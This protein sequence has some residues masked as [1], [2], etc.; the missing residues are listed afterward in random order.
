ML[1]PAGEFTMG[2]D[3]GEE[4]E[5][6]PHRVMITEPFYLQTTEVTQA[7]W[8]AVMDRN[9][10][11]L[12]GDNFPV[13][14][15]SWH[16]AQEFVSRLSMKEG[17]TYRL[18][19]EAEWEYACRAGLASEFCFGDS[20][21]ELGKYAWH[22]GNSGNKPQPVGG[23]KANKWG[24][25]DMH[26]NVFEWCQDWYSKD[27]YTRSPLE[28]PQGPVSSKDN[29][30]VARGGSIYVTN[31]CRSAFRAMEKSSNHCEVIGFRVLTSPK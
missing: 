24:L 28:D 18:P 21:E 4:N 9:P 26:G 5:K 22:A 17:V 20:V 12:K 19:T 16:E 3:S 31:R 2:S 25:H 30:H 1:I 7:Q 14:C 23:K 27:Y 8:N 15:V 29:L 13:E 6:P 11:R 10:S